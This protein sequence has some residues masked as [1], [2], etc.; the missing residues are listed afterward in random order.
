MKHKSD[1]SVHE[2]VGPCCDCGASSRSRLKATHTYA[3][4]EVSPETY[5]EVQKLLIDAGYAHAINDEGELDM[6]GVALQ[7]KQ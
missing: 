3:I 7:V 2:D 5:D 1:C 4:M 6:H